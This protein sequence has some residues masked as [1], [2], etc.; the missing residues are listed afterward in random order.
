MNEQGVRV[1]EE[2]IALADQA[3]RARESAVRGGASPGSTCCKPKSSSPT[4]RRVAFRPG[5]PSIPPI[6][7]CGRSCRCR[8][9]R[10]SRCAGLDERPE[11]LTRERA[12]RGFRRGPTCAR[13]RRA[14]HRGTLGRA[15]QRRVETQPGADRQPAVSGRW[16]RQPAEDGQPELH[17]RRR[18]AGTAV[19]RA[20]RRGETRGGA[21]AG[22][23]DRARAERRDRRRAARSGIGLDRFRERRT[24]WSSRSRRRWSWRARASPSRRRRTRT[25]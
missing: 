12:R 18:A 21:G 9:R 2:Q 20:R 3:A 11:R 8:S 7:R 19:C 10:R 13:L 24:K 6:R 16:A 1:A 22:Q 15:R 25:A 23:A 17:G 5:R 4:P 14:R